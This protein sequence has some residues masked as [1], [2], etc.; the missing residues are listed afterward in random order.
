[1]SRGHFIG[2]NHHRLMLADVERM[3]AYSQAIEA[4]VRPGQ[5][6]LDLGTGTGVLAMWA[7][8]AG[9][10]VVAVE[11]HDIIRVAE[12]L[13]LA[14]GLDARI[15]FVQADARALPAEPTFDLL[16]TEC[17]GNFFVTDEMQPVLRDA[18][19][20][21]APGASTLPLSISLHLAAATLPGWRELTFWEEP[22]GGLDLGAAL[23]FA[24]QA[25][26][27]VRCEPELVATD[28]ARLATFPLLEAPDTFELDARLE[29]KKPR[30]LHALIGWFEADLG[31]GVTLSTAPGVPTHWG[32]MAFPLPATPVRAGDTVRVQLRLSMDETLKGR[33]AW[34][35][36]VERPGRPAVPFQ[37]DSARRFDAEG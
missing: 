33:F 6:V 24:S 16:L 22:V 36:L 2:L 14:N 29:V 8:R 13:A 31:A 11:P 21:L 12:R 9:A 23:P 28:A 5:R 27:V 1:M 34:S 4:R 18:R 19:R 17:M 20:L 7:A 35:G 26:Y 32:Q 30:T 37:R 15:R 25:A 10:E 3:R